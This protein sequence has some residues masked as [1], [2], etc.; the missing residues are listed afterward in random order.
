MKDQIKF[1]TDTIE[2]A[3]SELEQKQWLI[4]KIEA[5]KRDVA[6]KFEA[7]EVSNFELQEQLTMAQIDAEEAKKEAANLSKQMINMSQQRCSTSP[8]QT[9]LDKSKEL[10]E[11]DGIKLI[12]FEPPDD[13]RLSIGLPRQ[14]EETGKF[15]AN[16]CIESEF[17]L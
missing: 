10:L 15:A 11:A 1:M 4:H 3:Q 17:L 16:P 13:L 7:L 9:K 12:D 6:R 5:E 2:K 8:R 14:S